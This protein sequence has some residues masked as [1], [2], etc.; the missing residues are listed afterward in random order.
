MSFCCIPCKCLLTLKLSL[1]PMGFEKLESWT[2]CKRL[3]LLH[4]TIWTSLKL[5]MRHRTAHR[6][7]ASMPLKVFTEVIPITCRLR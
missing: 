4:N 5:A 6:E 7:C 1:D 2:C 3:H